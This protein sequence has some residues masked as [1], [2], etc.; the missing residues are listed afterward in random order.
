MLDR[1]EKPKYVIERK[2]IRGQNKPEAGPREM[3]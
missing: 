1:K 2:D 3:A